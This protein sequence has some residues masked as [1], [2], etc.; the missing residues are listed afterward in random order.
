MQQSA[1]A[2]QWVALQQL[3]WAGTPLAYPGLFTNHAYQCR[4]FFFLFLSDKDEQV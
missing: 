2:G 1:H 3:W 4:L